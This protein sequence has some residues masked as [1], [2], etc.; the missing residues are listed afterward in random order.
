MHRYSLSQTS[1]E[2]K[3]LYQMN[4]Q[5][6]FSD[7]A[8]NY[9]KYRPDYPQ[10]AIASVIST[11]KSPIVAAD[12]GAGT[13]IS[14]RQLAEKGVKVIAI[15][16]NIEMRNAAETHPLV[17]FKTGTAEAT[18]LPDNSFNLVTCFQG[19]HWFNPE[20]TLAEFHRI[21]KPS[22]RLAIVWNNRNKDDEFTK[23]YS[24][25]L[26]QASQSHPAENEKRSRSISSVEKSELFV[27]IDSGNFAH[28][29][30]LDLS[31]LIGRALSASYI[32]KEGEKYKELV[33]NLQKLYHRRADSKGLVYLVY[34]TDVYLAEASG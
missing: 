13:G 6:R 2:A 20:P 14:S 1:M 29:Q 33:N 19:F 21:L 23:E 8:E 15:E 24:R 25:I 26:K 16:P 10:E 22:G 3:S 18:N 12:I 4:P 11:I 7:R 30:E 28:Q 17:E 31:G 27:K 34:R 32:P 5:G 9:A